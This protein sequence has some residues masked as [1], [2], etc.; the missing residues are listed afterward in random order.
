MCEDFLLFLK[1]E[2]D[3]DETLTPAVREYVFE[4][5]K[6][7]TLQPCETEAGNIPAKE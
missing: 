4:S 1:R 5:A 3:E 2:L 6:K 7:Q